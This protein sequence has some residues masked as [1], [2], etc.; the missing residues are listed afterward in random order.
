[1]SAH[2][3]LEGQKQTAA[4][5]ALPDSAA[6]GSCAEMP[7]TPLAHSGLNFAGRAGTVSKH[8]LADPQV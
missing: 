3:S 5:E 6:V 2:E 4:H 7:P 1:M 8:K